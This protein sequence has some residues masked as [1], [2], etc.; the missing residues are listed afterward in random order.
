MNVTNPL[1]SDLCFHRLHSVIFSFEYKSM[2]RSQRVYIIDQILKVSPRLSHLVVEWN[3][4]RS[5]SCRNTNVRYVH[6][7]LKTNCDDPNAHININHLFQLLPGICIFKTSD[8]HI[9]FNQSLVNFVLRII[10]TFHQLVQLTLNKEGY[11]PVKPEKQ[12]EIKQAI[13]DAGNT[14]LLDSNTYQITFPKG[15]RLTI[16]L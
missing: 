1:L 9:A 4:F 5:C 14:R 10:D 8:R 13:L 6:L 15:N 16:W 7:K 12:L 11:V 3:D 2:K